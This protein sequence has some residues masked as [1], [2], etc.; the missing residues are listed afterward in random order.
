MNNSGKQD[1][2]IFHEI[3]RNL[4]AISQFGSNR[5]EWW[6]NV[7]YAEVIEMRDAVS[8]KFKQVRVAN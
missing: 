7:N 2:A 1:S 6:L 8:T 3:R 4:S 5:A